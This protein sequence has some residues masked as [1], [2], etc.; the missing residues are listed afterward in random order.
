MKYSEKLKDPRWQK[1]RL[2]ILKRDNW[3]CQSCGEKD[4]VLH[5]HHRYYTKG[6]EPWEYPSKAL[7]TLCGECHWEEYMIWP[8][9]ERELIESFKEKFLA[10][11]AHEIAIALH[12]MT[13]THHPEV[14]ASAIA[15]ILGNEDMQKELVKRY[16][17]YANEG[18]SVSILQDR[19]KELDKIRGDKNA[20]RS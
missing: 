20:N 15:W 11:G 17:I 9:A 10:D 14:V 16:I 8:K 2:E 1:L 19:I 4:L 12:Y 6:K 5:V 18:D 7:L 13:L 3:M